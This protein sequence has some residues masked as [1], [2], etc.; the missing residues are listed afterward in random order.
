MM[1]PMMLRPAFPTTCVFTD[2]LKGTVMASPL[3]LSTRQPDFKNPRIVR[4]AE[5]V[6]AWAEKFIG[7][8][9]EIRVSNAEIRKVFANKDRDPGRWF[10]SNL[11]IQVGHYRV[12]EYPYAYILKMEGYE[13]IF[14]LLGREIPTEADIVGRRFEDILRGA[15]I[16]YRDNGMR[17]YHPVQNIRRNIRKKVFSGWWDYDI[18]ICAP[19]LVYQYAL[20]H[21]Q[22]VYGFNKNPF[23]AVA[24]LINEKLS[25]RQHV[26]E[27][28]GLDIN[29]AKEL[30]TMF[31]FR[32]NP[33]PHVSNALFRRLGCDP[34]RL[35]FFLHD[36]FIKALRRDIKAMWGYAFAHDRHERG[37]LWLQGVKA[38]VPHRNRWSHQMNIYFALER[39]VMDVI[40]GRLKAD[41]VT[42][43]L[44]H[45]GFMSQTKTDP[46]VLIAA[47]RE[48]GYEIRLSECPI[49]AAEEINERVDVEPLM[50]EVSVEE[51]NEEDLLEEGE[52]GAARQQIST[53]LYT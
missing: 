31:F 5:I 19:T 34:V 24:R 23:P 45:D 48:L 53:M 32:A 1:L 29:Q 26:A 50:D 15:P 20:K 52:E 22:W 37:R 27:L 7:R 10:Y 51:D 42:N 33:A 21:H 12:G 8:K 35:Y 25:I 4:R 47:V 2:T 14:R 18:E 44:M 28:T 6:L 38:S 3:I 16:E 49:G 9:K 11:L 46:S 39:R 41:G 40:L 17:R 30:L 36:D 13:K 43:V